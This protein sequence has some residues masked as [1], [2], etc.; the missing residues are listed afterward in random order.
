MVL[1]IPPP[2]QWAMAL[3]LLDL[4]YFCSVFP[5]CR[6]EL[7]NYLST[8]LDLAADRL[9]QFNQGTSPHSQITYPFISQHATINPWFH[10]PRCRWWGRLVLY[11]GGRMVCDNF[12]DLGCNI[13]SCHFLHT[14]S[15]CGGAHVRSSCPHNPTKHSLWLHRYLKMP[16]NI[17]ALKSALKDHLD[18][19]F[20]H[21][22]FHG[23]AFGFHQGIMVIPKSSVACHNLQCALVEPDT[24]D[25]L[26]VK[27]VNSSPHSAPHQASTASSPV[28]FFPCISYH[29]TCHQPHLSRWP[30]HLVG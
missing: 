27:E 22:I 21:F 7:D 2:P 4:L 30:W 29:H 10:P 14:C 9:Q 11:W 12:N 28:C 6:A 23:F 20:V 25:R 16:I 18:R 17:N 13:S 8:I 5:D 26:L 15:F 24:V 19:Q 3:P 1:F